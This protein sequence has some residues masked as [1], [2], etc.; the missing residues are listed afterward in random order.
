M[1]LKI[2]SAENAADSDLRKMFTLYAH[3]TSVE[4]LRIDGRAVAN[5]FFADGDE[6]GFAVPG[7][8][9]VMNEDGK[10]VASFGSAVIPAAGGYDGGE[11][12]QH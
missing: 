4:F 2:M 5:T 7:N 10:T 8:A 3:V 1:Y 12:H 9:Y 11:I 6:E